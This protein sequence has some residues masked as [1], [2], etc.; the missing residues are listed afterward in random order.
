MYSRASGSRSNRDGYGS[1]SGSG[2]GSG[3]EQTTH[4]VGSPVGL[5]DVAVM[6]AMAVGSCRSRDA[7]CGSRWLIGFC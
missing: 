3:G 1:G 6:M 5:V 7:E 2:D 4:K